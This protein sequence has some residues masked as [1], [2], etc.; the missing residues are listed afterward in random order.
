MSNSGAPSGLL[1]VV[2]A[3]SGTGKTTVVDK[4]VELCPNLQRS[5]SYTSRPSRPGE[6]DGV[7]Y[8]FISRS[9]FEEMV[10]E[11]AFLE[12]ADVFGN[13]YGT[14]R[15]E[16]EARL[17]TGAD[18]VLVIDVQGARQVRHRSTGTVAI[19]VLPPSPE[20]LERRLRQRS[21]E[22]EATIR[23]R[24]LTAHDEVSAVDE[25][26]Y[27]VVN[28]DDDLDR[29]VGELAAIVQAERA[30]WPRRRPAVAAILASFRK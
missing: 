14:S 9:L 19:F 29:C 22:A 26:D 12:Y 23:R 17:A 6:V 3:P 11:D 4:L 21:P 16:T 27:V 25:Y 2:S 1:F 8:N 5:R 18:L 15:K 7:D 13:L 10:H 30:R 20:S 24:L 28:D